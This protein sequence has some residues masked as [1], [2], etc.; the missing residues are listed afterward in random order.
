MAVAWCH[1]FIVATVETHRIKGPGQVEELKCL[2]SECEL[3]NIHQHLLRKGIHRLA[4]K[5]GDSL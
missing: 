3:R 4:L 5:D 1:L 2:G